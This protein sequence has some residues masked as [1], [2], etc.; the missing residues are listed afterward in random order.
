MTT[1]FISRH[2][3]AIEWAQHQGF[4][5]DN[6]VPHLEPQLV[7]AGDTVIGIL[8]VN[9]AADVCQRGAKYLNLTL[10]MPA[11][12]RGR[13]LTFDELCARGAR[14]EPFHVAALNIE[15]GNKK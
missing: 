14:L 12:M 9:L 1:W 15:L 4:D 3:G 6:W 10:D 11:H 2:P 13:E 5:V 7:Q 8:P